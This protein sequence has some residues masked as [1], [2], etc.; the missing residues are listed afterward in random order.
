MI[1]VAVAAA[2]LLAMIAAVT[3]FSYRL[4]GVPTARRWGNLLVPASQIVIVGL[5]LAYLIVYDMPAWL[6]AMVVAMALFCGFGD[7]ALFRALLAAEEKELAEE[8]A[9]ILEEQAAL[10][11]GYRESLLAEIDEAIDERSRIAQRLRAVDKLLLDGDC[12]RVSEGVREVAGAIGSGRR[13]CSHA[14][15]DALLR[16]KRQV[17]DE[18]GIESSF[19]VVLPVALGLPDI[20]VCA[21]FSNVMDNAIHACDE[22]EALHRFVDVRAKVAGGYLLLEVENSC[23][24]AGGG[25]SS[26][27]RRP[28]GEHIGDGEHRSPRLREHG[29]GL[30]IVRAIAQRY[31]GSCEAEREGGVFRTTVMLELQR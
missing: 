5:L 31:D 9:R 22:V 1:R 16:A 17:C 6:F 28:F 24:E 19:E 7:V 15:V 21:V 27:E 25:P 12:E 13:L 20:D 11:E 30:I 8:R 26:A 2:S 18:K 3:F 23:S 14:A 4:R 10:Q 29:W